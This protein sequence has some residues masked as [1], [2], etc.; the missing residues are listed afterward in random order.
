MMPGAG[1]FAVWRH[2][3]EFLGIVHDDLG[4][5]QKQS[6]HGILA[7]E[8]PGN[9]CPHV[10]VLSL[11]LRIESDVLFVQIRMGLCSALERWKPERRLRAA[12]GRE[13]RRCVYSRVKEPVQEIRGIRPK[14]LKTNASVHF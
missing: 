1:H 10:A 14:P 6:P 13:P 11:E 7:P 12:R 5:A 4:A 3:D 2:P 9:G 8:P